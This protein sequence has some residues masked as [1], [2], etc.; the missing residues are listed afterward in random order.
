MFAPRPDSPVLPP[1][2]VSEAELGPEADLLTPAL[3][4]RDPVVE[5]A[6]AKSGLRVDFTTNRTSRV[7]LVCLC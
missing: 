1:P 5:L 7:L 2:R 3:E 4:A 6:G